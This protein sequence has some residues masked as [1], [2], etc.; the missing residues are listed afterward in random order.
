MS[1]RVTVTRPQDPNASLLTWWPERHLSPE[2]EL[3]VGPDEVAVFAEGQSVL[4]VVGSGRH[5]ITAKTHP[6]LQKYLEK[7]LFTGT[8]VI[9]VCFITTAEVDGL[10]CQGPL[11]I[12]D[13]NREITVK[14]DAPF[15]V[16]VIDP[17][18][19]IDLVPDLSDDVDEDTVEEWIQ[20][21]VFEHIED[22]LTALGTDADEEA[23]MVDVSK[24]ASPKLR[25]VGVALTG[26]DRFEVK[27]V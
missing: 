8:H 11:G 4:E 17:V 27:A 18:A 13:G 20:E 10:R 19:L 14:V 26:F 21:E 24:R 3:V 2:T 23:L 9:D 12:E 6:K 22:A 1:T 7:H 16:R 15:R 5:V 25:E